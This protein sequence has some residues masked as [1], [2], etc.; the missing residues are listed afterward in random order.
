MGETAEI[1]YTRWK[2]EIS[3]ASNK[4]LPPNTRP[5]SPKPTAVTQQSK[6]GG[7]MCISL[8][9]YRPDFL[10]LFNDIFCIFFSHPCTLWPTEHEHFSQAGVETTCQR[11]VDFF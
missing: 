4:N 6:E 8:T 11:N 9:R 3:F 7:R 2:R 10:E 5:F 1:A